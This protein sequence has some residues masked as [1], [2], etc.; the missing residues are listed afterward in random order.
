MLFHQTP[1]SNF[2]TDFERTGF[3]PAGSS[4]A[5]KL[6]YK[7]RDCKKVIFDIVL[8]QNGLNLSTNLIQSQLT[9][10]LVYSSQHKITAAPGPR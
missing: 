8:V 3:E 6:F 1:D 5:L 7:G 2:G 4:P 10:Q 9:S